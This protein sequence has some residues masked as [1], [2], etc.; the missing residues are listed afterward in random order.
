MSKRLSAAVLPLYLALCLLLGGSSQGHWGNLALQL[1][2]L[3]L[4]AWAMLSRQPATPSE[5]ALMWFAATLVALLAL[6]LIPLPPAIW[7][8]LPG[9]D[10]VTDGFALLGQ[11]LPWMPLSLAPFETLASLLALLPALAM[12]AVMI[13]RRSDRPALLVGAMLLVAITG[14]GLGLL[15]VGSSNHDWYLYPISAFGNAAGFFANSNHMGALLLLCVPLVAAVA[16]ERWRSAGDVKARTLTAAVTVAVGAMLTIGVALNGSLAILALA[17]PVL[18]LSLVIFG[19]LV[20]RRFHRAIIGVAI[21]AM[22]G[23]IG[24][25]AA[26]YD[27]AGINNQSSIISRADIWSRTVDAIGDHGLAGSGIGSFP[28]IYRQYEDSARVDRFF[29]NHAH[30][31]Y[32]EV[33]LE[34][35]VPGLLLLAAFLLWWGRTALAAWRGPSGDA[36]ARAAAVG[37]GVILLHSLVDFPLRTAALSALFAMCLALM[38]RRPTPVV[39]D[40]QPEDLWPTRHLSIGDQS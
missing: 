26:T 34:A 32:L 20:P 30:N 13:R 10:F 17:L 37:S 1:G 35:G 31:D 4:L 38:V 36:Y 23:T 5:R 39:R 24:V 29:A 16:G 21:I 3:A 12:L 33:A 27:R 2:A 6:Q 14:I 7:M 18:L 8:R 9:R 28:A 19:E 15:Q 11:P 22:I 25:G 40:D